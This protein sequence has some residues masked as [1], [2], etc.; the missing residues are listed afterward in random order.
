MPFAILFECLATC[1]LYGADKLLDDFEFM[2]Q[3]RF[4]LRRYFKFT[5]SY[6]TPVYAIG[7]VVV[8]LITF[9]KS[10]WTLL[11]G[12]DDFP[13]W[14]DV[15]GCVVVAVQIIALIVPL[16]LNWGEFQARPIYHARRNLHESIP[17][18]ED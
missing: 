17:L 18:L 9:H 14:S 7:I 10:G 13:W 5:W 6:A 11:S 8:S 12:R 3:R 15:I 16:V 4:P 2:L 1:H